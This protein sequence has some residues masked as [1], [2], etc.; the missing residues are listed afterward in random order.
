MSSVHKCINK[1]EVIIIGSH[2]RVLAIILLILIP[3]KG[4]SQETDTIPFYIQMLRITEAYSIYKID[5]S[6]RVDTLSSWLNEPTEIFLFY[7]KNTDTLFFR[8]EQKDSIILMGLTVSIPNPGF[9]SVN[10]KDT[11]FFAG[12]IT[13]LNWYGEG[14]LMKEYITDSFQNRKKMY[15]FLHFSLPFKNMELQVYGYDANPL[16]K[17]DP[18]MNSIRDEAEQRPK[19]NEN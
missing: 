5:D 9:S 13:Y 10:R 3:A 11:E 7:V 16:T 17:N 8:M 4:K 1:L 15:Y 14:A 18:L 2:L 6:V 12:N 19:T